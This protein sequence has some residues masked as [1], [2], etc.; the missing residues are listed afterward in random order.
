MSNTVIAKQLTDKRKNLTKTI[1]ALCSIAENDNS[2]K[3]IKHILSSLD[4]C[5]NVQ[6]TIAY[7]EKHID[8]QK[9]QAIFTKSEISKK[10]TLDD[11][12]LNRIN[13]IIQIN[14]TLKILKSKT[15]PLEQNVTVYI[16]S[17]F[18]QEKYYGACG[19]VVITPEQKIKFYKCSPDLPVMPSA[20]AYEVACVIYAITLAQICCNGK[21][22]KLTIVCNNNELRNYVEKKYLIDESSPESAEVKLSLWL[23]NILQKIK[24][25]HVCKDIVLVKTNNSTDERYLQKAK[26]L[27]YEKLRHKGNSI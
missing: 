23:H 8:M 14:S 20:I 26:D 21:I 10:R 7:I 18:C 4:K 17:C 22:L 19:S 13:S 11:V 9:A 24:K 15:Q 3:T 6:D 5:S 2:T 1:K 12:L 25:S 16:A 27:A